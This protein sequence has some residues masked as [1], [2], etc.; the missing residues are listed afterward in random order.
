MLSGP[1]E[2]KGLP[3]VQVLMSTVC[4]ESV[5][6]SVLLDDSVMTQ[7]PHG[8]PL[9]GDQLAHTLDQL[10]II[11]PPPPASSFNCV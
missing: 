3:P 1:Q 9:H 11:N 4:V 5:S 8:N 2:W 6:Y 7:L 10:Y